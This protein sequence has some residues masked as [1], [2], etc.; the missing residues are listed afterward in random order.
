MSTTLTP[1]HRRELR[2]RAH[3]LKPIVLVGSAGVTDA[4]VTELDR[5]LD[6]HELLKL[7]FH[8]GDR[9]EVSAA[10]KRLCTTLG[11]A[12]VQRIGRTAT[13]YRERPADSEQARGERRRAQT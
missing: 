9:D 7:R 4:V 10:L 11:A 13:L 8:Q 2:A 6:H 1:K 12:Q 3:A 5:S